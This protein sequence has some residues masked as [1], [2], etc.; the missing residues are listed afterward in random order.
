M[1]SKGVLWVITSQEVSLLFEWVKLYNGFHGNLLILLTRCKNW[2]QKQ[3]T[4]NTKWPGKRPWMW[5]TFAWGCRWVCTQGHQW[6]E[7]SQC[8]NIAFV[9]LGF[10]GLII[11][12]NILRQSW[13]GCCAGSDRLKFAPL[14]PFGDC[15]GVW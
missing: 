1:L 15:S 11:N 5:K 13:T 12:D 4:A 7:S 8:F 9:N 2:Y 10:C 14:A 3:C 6:M